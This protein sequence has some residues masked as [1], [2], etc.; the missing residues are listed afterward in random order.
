M[1]LYDYQCVRCGPFKE[2]RP[3]SQW[4]KDTACPKCGDASKRTI[5]KARLQCLSR[6][7]RIAHERNERS[8]DEPRVMRRAELDA[9]HGHIPRHGH[10]RGRSMYRSSVLGHVH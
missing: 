9:S 8:A 4:N 5:A 2:L 10:Q 3:L 6:N 7:A 1:P